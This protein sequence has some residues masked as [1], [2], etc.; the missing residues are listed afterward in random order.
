MESDSR[1]FLV[2]R[3]RKVSLLVPD[4]TEA[5]VLLPGFLDTFTIVRT[6]KE[7]EVS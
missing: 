7:Q 5:N 3:G 2:L 4:I 1:L 6:T